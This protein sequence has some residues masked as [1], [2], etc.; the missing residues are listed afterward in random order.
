MKKNLTQI[1]ATF[2]LFFAAWSSMQAQ[3]TDT[4]PIVIDLTI[5][6]VTSRLNPG[7]ACGFEY[8]SGWGGIFTEATCLDVAWGF[9]VGNP[10]APLPDSLNCDS[11]PAGSLTGKAGLARRGGCEFGVKALNLEKAGA[12]VAV[13]I[14]NNGNAGP[15]VSTDPCF[16]GPMGAGAVGSQVTIPAIYLARQTGNAIAAAINAGQAVS[17]CF[18]P[19]AMFNDAAETQ[20]MT[21]LS[22]R[23]SLFLIRTDI[24]N[25]S[26]ATVENVSA[27]AFITEPDGNVVELESNVISEIAPGVDSIAGFP[28]YFPFQQGL[29]TVTYTNNTF[30]EPYDTLKRSF[31]I[32]ATTF[33]T[34]NGQNI[35]N[36]SPT[37]ANFISAA[38]NRTFSVAARYLTGSMENTKANGVTFG[39]GNPQQVVSGNPVNDVISVALYD[40]DINGDGLNDMVNNTPLTAQFSDYLTQL[41]GFGE[42]TIDASVPSNQ[43]VTV[44]LLD[45]DGNSGVTLKPNHFYYVLLTYD[46]K[47]SMGDTSVSFTLAGPVNYLLFTGV[48]P[49]TPI[50]TQ[51]F[52]NGGFGNDI[53]IA[54]L[55]TDAVVSV[56]AKPVLSESK[57]K[58]L[59]N[60][61]N[62]Q[63]VLD[64][65]LAAQNDM[66]ISLMDF[67]GR[68]LQTIT[69]KEFQSG[70]VTVNTQSYASGNYVLWVRTSNEG[71]RAIPVMICH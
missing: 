31:E 48:G 33:A 64:M 8:A 51:S 59:S 38:G 9:D 19:V 39:I 69:K 36:G 3:G 11:V 29:Y 10:M 18:Y 20:Y 53:P 5:N 45:V 37:V 30:T 56:P 66:V 68:A 15:P 2:M 63:L 49:A 44:P 26:S 22:H 55:E 43:L 34:D 65:E 54:R 13:I 4:R 47:P 70:Q 24:V 25:R 14:N 61:A 1:M 40:A 21:P 28:L 46:G 42:Y 71:T 16:V 12:S 23:D 32:S 6:G 27:K 67:E 60:P 41:A 35:S 57:Y 50:R 7:V 58:V 52:F 17:I 62:E